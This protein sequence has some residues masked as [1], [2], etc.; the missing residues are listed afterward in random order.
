[1]ARDD[2]AAHDRP[3]FTNAFGFGALSFARQRGAGPRLE[4][5]HGPPLRN[6]G[7]RRVRARL[8]ADRRCV[9][10]VE[11]PRATRPDQ[12]AGAAGAAKPPGHRPVRPGVH[13]LE[14]PDADRLVHRGRGDLPALQRT[15]RPSR[16][17]RAGRRQPRRLPAVHQ[18]VLE[19]RRRPL[20]VQG[21]PR[22]VLDPDPPDGRL[23]R[24]RDPGELRSAHRLGIDPGDR[25]LVGDVARSPPAGCPEVDAMAGGL[26]EIRSGFTALPEILRFGL[27]IDP[28]IAGHRSVRAGRNLGPRRLRIPGRRW[29]MEPGVGAQSAIRRAQLQARRD[30]VPHSGR[31]TRRRGQSWA[32]IGHSS[33]H[34]ATSRPR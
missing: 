10:P 32:S 11:R 21:R 23:S 34:S 9:V 7:D 2:S 8:R 20:R 18:P 12:D 15:D 24:A 27:K 19:H 33:T 22:P 16:A 6:H 17:V 13:L 3:S 4:H 25:R 5:P 29:R 28:R 14:R 1:M 26:G 30:G 31:A